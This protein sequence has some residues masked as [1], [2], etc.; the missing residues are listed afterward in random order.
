VTT[1]VAA[2]ALVAALAC[3]VH[4]L[5]RSRRGNAEGCLPSRRPTDRLADRQ[6]RLAQEL[7]RLANHRG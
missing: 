3:P 1:V 2:V 7:E 5:W 6:A 4:M